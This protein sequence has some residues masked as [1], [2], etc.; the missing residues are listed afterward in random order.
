LPKFGIVVRLCEQVGVI[1]NVMEVA[2]SY[3][4]HVHYFQHEP[5]L[6]LIDLFVQCLWHL[7]YKHRAPTVNCEL[8][9]FDITFA[10]LIPATNVH[11]VEELEFLNVKLRS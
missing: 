7:F 1:F 2:E 3:L 6:H 10:I 8:H 11:T 4:H 5:V 9:F